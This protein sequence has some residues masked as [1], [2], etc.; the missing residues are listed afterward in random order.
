MAADGSVHM[1]HYDVDLFV[2]W[3]M[4]TRSGQAVSPSGQTPEPTF[5]LD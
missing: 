5:T 4:S 3:A 2:L 1:I